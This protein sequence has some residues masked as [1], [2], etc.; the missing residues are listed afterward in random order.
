[1]RLNQKPKKKI[2]KSDKKVTDPY[3]MNIHQILLFDSVLL[4]SIVTAKK[5]IQSGAD[6]NLICGD[7]FTITHQQ[8]LLYMAAYK[9]FLDI[10]RLL[11]SQKANVNQTIDDGSTPLLVACQQKHTRVVQELL[12]N[13]ATANISDKDGE[14]PLFAAAGVGALA[15][16]A[17]LINT[18]V[19]VDTRNKLKSATALF[20]ASQGGFRDVAGFLL[21]RKADVNLLRSDNTSA[22]HIAVERNHLSVA[23]LLIDQKANLNIRNNA[24][25]TAYE[26]ALR[27]NNKPMI[28]F[29]ADLMPYQQRFIQEVK[30][31]LFQWKK[32]FPAISA[33]KNFIENLSDK[34]AKLENSDEVFLSIKEALKGTDYSLVKDEL[35]SMK[36]LL[37]SCM[38]NYNEQK[39][40]D[41]LLEQKSLMVAGASRAV[42]EAV[43][44][45]TTTSTSTLNLMPTSTPASTPIVDPTKVQDENASFRMG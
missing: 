26:Y 6:V 5:A 12:E 40:Q 4:G 1:M 42:E 39:K 7:E 28:D 32:F 44:T 14:T 18:G 33:A 27:G 11:I 13:K 35:N 17:L 45:K 36:N 37:I 38:K 24:G 20:I 16:V 9:G 3:S 29:L 34:I 43:E 23:K 10:V 30:N 2:A 22:L 41:L 15:I 8:T 25:F 31:I 19:E 21:S